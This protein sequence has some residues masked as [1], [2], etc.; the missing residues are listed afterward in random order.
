M[1][2]CSIHWRSCHTM[3]IPVTGANGF[4]GRVL[5]DHISNQK[6]NAYALLRKPQE[7]LNVK[8][9]FIVEDFLN[10]NE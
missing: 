3:N 9:S 6:L 5:C 10:F 1:D 4:I 2:P 7:G 8:D